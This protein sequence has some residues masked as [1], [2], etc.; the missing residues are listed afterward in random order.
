MR[1]I[2][3]GRNPEAY[4]GV[5]EHGIMFSDPHMDEAHCAIIQRD[6]GTFMVRDLGSTNG[7]FI[8][9]S[10]FG[11]SNPLAAHR[12]EVARRIEGTTALPK[13]TRVRIGRTTL[14]WVADR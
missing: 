11:R 10:Q 2:I 4:V 9:Y 13:G 8:I 3:F 1:T 6:D 5:G 14:P 7:T 12:G